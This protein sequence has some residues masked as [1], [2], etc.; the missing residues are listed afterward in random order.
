MWVIQA[1]H[2]TLFQVVVDNHAVRHIV[3]CR[4]FLLLAK[5]G[6]AV[7]ALTAWNQGAILTGKQSRGA[8]DVDIVL[9]IRGWDVPRVQGAV[10][11]CPD[12]VG[13]R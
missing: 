8:R 2:Q 1:R 12:A 7:L 10:L 13:A 11:G 9:V 6:K 4:H 5:G 3:V